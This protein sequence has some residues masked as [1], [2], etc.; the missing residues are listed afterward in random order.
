MKKKILWAVVMAA[1]ISCNENSL[2]PDAKN[3]CLNPMNNSSSV[4]HGLRNADDS[5]DDRMNEC[6]YY[7]GAGIVHLMQNPTHREKLLDKTRY[8]AKGEGLVDDFFNGDE[9][10]LKDFNKFLEDNRD[11]FTYD[12]GNY[13]ELK[14]LMSYQDVSYEPCIYFYNIQDAVTGEDDMSQYT[15]GIGESVTANDEIPAYRVVLGE[16]SITETLVAESNQESASPILIITNYTDA[17]IETTD[18]IELE[19]NLDRDYTVDQHRITVDYEGTGNSDY[20]GSYRALTTFMG[21]NGISDTKLG[22]HINSI[23]DSQIGTTFNADLQLNE[24]NNE[25]GYWFVTHERDWYA[26]KKP[27]LVNATNGA[28]QNIAVECAM[29]YN[30]EFFQRIYINFVNM[31]TVTSNEKGTL[32]VTVQ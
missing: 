31:N 30:H 8:N 13:N 6:L 14:S 25:N 4:F 17:F 11:C 12:F 20:Q 29:K 32:R 26:S 16:S 9:A 23:S 5:E 19:E 27:V 28:P 22:H 21:V 3:D 18:D 1:L 2:S 24:F 10:M 7:M 15:V